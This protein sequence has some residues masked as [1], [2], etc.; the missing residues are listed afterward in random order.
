MT[1]QARSDIALL[2]RRAGFG[3]RPAE[4][5]AWATEGYEPAVE[6]LLAGTG[7]APDPTGDRVAPPSF[8]P[9]P[10]PAGPKGSPQA[11]AA[12]KAINRDFAAELAALQQWW[13]D[14]M[15]VTSTPLREKLTLLWHGHFA[16]GVSKVRDP[17][18]MYM[19]NEL[20]RTAGAG[21]FE[22]LTQAVAKDGAMMIWL[23]TG[24]D[25]K[26]HPNENFARE[27]MELFTLG[28]GNY[29]QDDV[30]AAARGFTGWTFDRRTLRFVYR[31]A[32][33]Y[34]GTSTYLGHSGELTGEEVISIAVHQPASPRF[35]AAKLWSHLAYPVSPSDPV[36]GDLLGA[37][38]S[39]LDLTSL[40]RAIFLH[41]GFRSP[42]A[43][44]GMVKQPIEYLVGAARALGLDARLDRLGPDGGVPTTPAATGTRPASRSLAQAATLL[45]Q[46]PFNPPNVGG[47]GENTYWLDTATADLRLEIALVLARAADLSGVTAQPVSARPAAVA[48][49]LGLDGWGA[50]TAAALAHQAAE[51]EALVALALTAPEYVLA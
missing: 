8:T 42:S 10:T 37:Y 17:Q 38:G 7:S 16:T 34:A 9:Y 27:M 44:T 35:V 11:L 4:L 21:S 32:Q 41:P 23:D 26:A 50:T 19:Q 12:A 47:W 20:F 40:L 25:K 46:T 31:P 22:A 3:A 6:R 36:I 30:V 45:A 51:P 24:T 48:E 43:R 39:G 28:L 5:D 15:I 18:L 2:Y 33:H 49:L 13:M 29:T 14:R 1:D